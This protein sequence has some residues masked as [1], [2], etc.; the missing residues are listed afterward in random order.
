MDTRHYWKPLSE[1]INDYVNHPEAKSM[2]D[3]G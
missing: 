2:G 3:I 1:L